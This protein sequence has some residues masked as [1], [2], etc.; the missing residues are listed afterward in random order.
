MWTVLWKGRVPLP[1]VKTASTKKEARVKK[2][3]GT[4]RVAATSAPKPLVMGASWETTAR[5]VFRTLAT[6]VSSSQGRIVARSITSQEIPDDPRP[7][8]RGIGRRGR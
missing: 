5:P 4:C 8:S 6:T 2:G 7:V 3:L 1:G